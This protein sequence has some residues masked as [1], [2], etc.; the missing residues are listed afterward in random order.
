MNNKRLFLLISLLT[1]LISCK[2]NVNNSYDLKVKT[3]QEYVKILSKTKNDTDTVISKF[4]NYLKNTKNKITD[5]DILYNKKLDKVQNYFFILGVYEL[6]IELT[7]IFN[8]K[9]NINDINEYISFYTTFSQSM[10]NELGDCNVYF[11][12]KL[13]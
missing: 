1:I 11:K 8:G 7:K 9:Y 2:S 4:E 10:Y 13:K 6:N 12:E 3:Y 5:D